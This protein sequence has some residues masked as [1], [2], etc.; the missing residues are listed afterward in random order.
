MK[1]RFSTPVVTRSSSFKD[2]Q[3]FV[4]IFK[5]REGEFIM[6][7][8]KGQST[9]TSINLDSEMFEKVRTLSLIVNIPVSHIIQ[10]ALSEYF[11]HH[12]DMDEKV[13]EV[14]KLIGELKTQFE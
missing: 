7:K 14:G 13:K 10:K 8:E 4:E 1:R 11:E 5:E 6:A 2:N 12:A 9:T 3:I